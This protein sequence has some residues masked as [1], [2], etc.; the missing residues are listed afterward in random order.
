[1]IGVVGHGAFG[2]VLK[3]KNKLDSRFYAIK[4]I[5]TNPNSK[6]YNKQIIREIKLL[7]RLNHENVVR[8][9]STWAERYEEIY[10]HKR[11][12]SKSHE[13]SH[14]ESDSKNTSQVIRF[15]KVTEHHDPSDVST[16][17][18][19]SNIGGINWVKKS[20]GERAFSSISGSGID[21]R[22]PTSESGGSEGSESEEA[23]DLSGSESD[24][25]DIKFE[26]HDSDESVEI[27]EKKEKK[28][29]KKATFFIESAKTDDTDDSVIFAE[30][31]SNHVSR[32]YSSK[33]SVSASKEMKDSYDE[34][35]FIEEGSDSDEEDGLDK[36]LNS[37]VNRQFIY[38]QVIWL[39]NASNI[40]YHFI[41]D[42]LQDGILRW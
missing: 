4:R 23:R 29:T 3:V 30:G 20:S 38:I 18:E 32:S 19:D 12:R 16:S 31:S 24:D 22:H 17:S 27:D 6:V 26:D 8:Y 36:S 1:M 28:N 40:M 11:M 13:S 39:Y 37:K 35:E 25:D 5:R 21:L 10:D 34:E 41:N 9:Y 2:E 15:R 42:F 7:S 14:S 33:S